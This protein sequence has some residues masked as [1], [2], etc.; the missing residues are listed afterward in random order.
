MRHAGAAQLPA[1]PRRRV[2]EGG[3]SLAL[4][5]TQQQ[6]MGAAPQSADLRVAL[7][8]CSLLTNLSQLDR[9]KPAPRPKRAK[10]TEEE[11]AAMARRAPPRASHGKSYNEQEAFKGLGHAL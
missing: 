1:W 9:P 8:A 10:L 2:A 7:P 6:S 11:R 5:H 4:S 3:L